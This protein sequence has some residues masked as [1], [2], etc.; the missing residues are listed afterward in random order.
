MI[1]RLM[2][3]NISLEKDVKRSLFEGNG[4]ILQHRSI[5]QFSFRYR[6]Q[7]EKTIKKR[8]N[9]GENCAGSAVSG[10]VKP[11]TTSH[12]LADSRSLCT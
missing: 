11:E 2:I 7:K 4:K 5:D 8:G 10:A 6:S 1:N 3:S 12:Q 9:S